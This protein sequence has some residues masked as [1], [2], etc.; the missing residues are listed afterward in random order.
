V[1]LSIFCKVGGRIFLWGTHCIIVSLQ[2]PA[3]T[4]NKES[5]Y[6]FVLFA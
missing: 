4:S 6:S 5:K 2:K 3:I 1:E